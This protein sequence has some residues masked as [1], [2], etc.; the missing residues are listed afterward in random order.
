MKY[1]RRLVSVKNE[2]VVLGG[3]VL[4]MTKDANNQFM[5]DIK[6]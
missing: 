4:C 6:K 3:Y 2:G 5:H 1:W